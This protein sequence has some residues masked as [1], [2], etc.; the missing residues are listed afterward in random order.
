MMDTS[1]SLPLKLL[2]NKMKG[3]KTYINTLVDRLLPQIEASLPDTNQSKLK[4]ELRYLENR[5]TIMDDLF[6]QFLEHPDTS[7]K[8]VDDYTQYNLSVRDTVQRGLDKLNLVAGDPISGSAG[9]M[10][11]NSTRISNQANHSIARD[12]L[13]HANLPKLE[14]PLF[15]GGDGCWREYRSFLEMFNAMVDSDPDLS[16]T[17]K[18]QYLRRSLKGEAETLISHLDPVASNYHLYL[19]TLQDAYQVGRRK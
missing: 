2:K 1:L 9:G 16:V 5:L 15:Y 10:H 8:L 13:A 19:K 14:L 7:E 6:N 4:S 18:I 17:L 11:L 3:H 12:I